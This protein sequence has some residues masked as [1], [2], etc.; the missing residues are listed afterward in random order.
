MDDLS[1]VTIRKTAPITAVDLIDSTRRIV[2]VRGSNFVNVLKVN[3]AGQEIKN[4]I[5][6]SV[7]EIRFT[8]PPP[9]LDLSQSVQVI[10]DASSKV[11]ANL[12]S[13]LI[14]VSVNLAAPSRGFNRILQKFIKILLTEKGS[15][16]FNLDEGT[17]L[18]S[19][20]GSSNPDTTLIDLSV[21]DAFSQISSLQSSATLSASEIIT[22]VSVV[23]SYFDPRRASIN[24]ELEVETAN[25]L[26]VFTEVSI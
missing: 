24:I 14:D 25:G 5:V 17:A 20:V 22:S 9:P 26:A 7:S 15:N 13:S 11:S 6:P 4:F 2:S 12:T 23:R 21:D 1:L 19:L 3:F 18:P 10:I 8:L 16:F